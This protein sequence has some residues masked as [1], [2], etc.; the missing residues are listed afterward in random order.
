VLNTRVNGQVLGRGK[1]EVSFYCF[2]APVE[3]LMGL[4]TAREVCLLQGLMHVF[5]KIRH[6]SATTSLARECH[7]LIESTPPEL[8]FQHR[9]HLLEVVSAIFS[10]ELNQ[11]QVDRGGLAAADEHFAQVLN[12][13]SSADIMNVSVQ[14]LAGRFG[15][16]RRHLSRV[17]HQ[18][19]GTT[20]AELK[21][22]LRLL[23]AADLLLNPDAKVINVAE[24]CGFNHL[25]LFNACFK[26]RF[27]VSPGHWRKLAPD[28]RSQAV[29]ES[30][31]DGKAAAPGNGKPVEKAPAQAG[32][33]GKGAKTSHGSNGN[34]GDEPTKPNIP[35]SLLAKFQQA[36]AAQSGQHAK[37]LV[38]HKFDNTGD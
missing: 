31:Q 22:E 23:K 12:Q 17:F 16:S 9:C 19:F 18:H 4:F 6:Y 28:A 2:A 11:V 36:G 37:P 20:L 29:G 13:L 21:M 27:G 3:H 38:L 15:W 30:K 1:G 25:G 8:S 34:N 24:A 32:K 14:E 5:D 33:N 26:R 10:A 35:A 7:R